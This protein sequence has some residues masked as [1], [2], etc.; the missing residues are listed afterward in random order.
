MAS[1]ALQRTTDPEKG[2]QIMLGGIAFRIGTSEDTNYARP[3]TS[4][5]YPLFSIRRLVWSFWSA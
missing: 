2:A 4:L 3:L 1:S 5:Q